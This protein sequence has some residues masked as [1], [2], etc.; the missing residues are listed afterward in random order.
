MK[1][2]EGKNSRDT[3]VLFSTFVIF[4]ILLLG[5][6]TTSQDVFAT[7]NETPMDGSC[8]GGLKNDDGGPTMIDVGAG[9][10]I[11][12]VCVK[13][14]SESINDGQH[15]VLVTMDTTIAYCYVVDFSADRSKVTITEEDGCKAISH[16]DYFVIPGDMI[17]GHGIPNDKTS[18]LV[19]GSQVTTSWMIPLLVSAV[20]IG[21]FIVSYK[22]E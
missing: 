15:S 14:G 10:E 11:T 6:V 12:G 4:S 22:K 21:I 1:I 3:R 8:E 20:G 16:I 18:L 2:R 17:G 19:A 9:S 13:S 5:S 7:G